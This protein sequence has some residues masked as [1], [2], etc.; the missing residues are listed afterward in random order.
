MKV[1]MT[2]LGCQGEF[3]PINFERR[4]RW[5]SSVGL[6]LLLSGATGLLMA[7]ADYLEA[8]DFLERQESKSAHLD[9]Q[10]SKLSRSTQ[11]SVVK[12]DPVEWRSLQMLSDELTYPLNQQFLAVEQA[13]S[14]QV[15]VLSL[16]PEPKAGRLK[17][18][19]EAKALDDAIVFA[20]QLK[21]KAGFRSVDVTHHE[22]R[23]VGAVRVLGFSILAQ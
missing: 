20:E 14:D 22:Y 13:L 9:Q 17:I 2:S 6:V 11:V 19:G 4:R 23:M 15:A 5:F 1:K 3:L 10:I 8:A 16:Q 7:V 21:V 12:M 18:L